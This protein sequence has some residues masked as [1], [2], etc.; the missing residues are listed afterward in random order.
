MI[1]DVLSNLSRPPNKKQKAAIKI[2]TLS[3]LKNRLNFNLDRYP[4]QAINN[5]I[6][7]LIPMVAYRYV[8]IPVKEASVINTAASCAE[9]KNNARKI[10]ITGEITFSPDTRERNRI[11]T[12]E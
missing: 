11:M 8:E 6:P 3:V 4:R 10:Q 2:I 9:G 12:K 7:A 5:N 1:I